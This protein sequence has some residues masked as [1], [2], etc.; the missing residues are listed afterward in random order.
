MPRCRTDPPD[1]PAE[2]RTSHT[3]DAPPLRETLRLSNSKVAARSHPPSSADE[4]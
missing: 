4:A 1:R 2:Q 3:S